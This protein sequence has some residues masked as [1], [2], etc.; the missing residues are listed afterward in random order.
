MVA[1]VD[2]GGTSHLDAYESLLEGELSYSAIDD[3]GHQAAGSIDSTIIPPIAWKLGKKVRFCTFIK[4]K[5]KI[6]L[7]Q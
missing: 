2:A 6:I 5:K 1:A 4:R 3:S 7:N